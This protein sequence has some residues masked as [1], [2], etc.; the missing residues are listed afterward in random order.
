[1]RN[2]IKENILDAHSVVSIWN[3]SYKDFKRLYAEKVNQLFNE[4]LPKL[5]Y[6][7][8]KSKG[9]IDERWEYQRGNFDFDVKHL[10]GWLI[11][12]KNWKSSGVGVFSTREGFGKYVDNR[13]DSKNY[14]PRAFYPTLRSKTYALKRKNYNDDYC[15]LTGCRK[16][17]DEQKKR[18]KGYDGRYELWWSYFPENS[19]HFWLDEHWKEIKPNGTTV[20]YISSF[21]EK[22]I[23]ACEADI[24]EIEGMSNN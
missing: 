21:L 22:L 13:N 17:F 12:K 24:D 2:I 4:E 14:F 3:D 11:K 10:Q 15:N 23:K 7:D 16:E 5:V 6:D 20:K 8:L 1:M 9:V 18:H 19:Y